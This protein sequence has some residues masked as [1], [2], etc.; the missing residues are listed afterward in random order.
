MR[1]QESGALILAFAVQKAGA[2]WSKGDQTAIDPCREYVHKASRVHKAR[3]AHQSY[4]IITLLHRHSSHWILSF[5]IIN[6]AGNTSQEH[7]E[8]PQQP[9]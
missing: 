3:R 4:G 2:Y 7:I 6:S 9:K 5:T 8:M 1:G